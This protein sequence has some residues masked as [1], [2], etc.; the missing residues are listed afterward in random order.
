MLNELREQL[1]AIAQTPICIDVDGSIRTTK[2]RQAALFPGSFNPLHDGHTTLAEVAERVLG[3]PVAFEISIENVDKPDLTFD[4]L[5]RRL[6]PFR[7]R[8][9]V[10]VTRAATFERKSELFPGCHFILGYDTAIRLMDARYYQNDP[11]RRDGCLRKLMERDCR[12]LVG[13]RLHGGQFRTWDRSE[14]PTEFRELFLSLEEQ[15]FRVDRSSTEL[16][17]G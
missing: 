7:N 15:E 1:I 11:V 4:E 2:P 8:A 16:R 14:A 6:A 17:I 10:W 5:I 9:P 13:G 12:I 3:R